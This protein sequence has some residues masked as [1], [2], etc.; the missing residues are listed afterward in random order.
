MRK[1]HVDRNAY[2][3]IGLGLFGTALALELVHAGKHVIVLDNDE[4]KLNG[5]KEDITSAHLVS[6]ITAEVLQDSGISDCGTVVIAIGR[7]IESNILA[8]LTVKE[9]G[10]PRVISKAMSD[11]HGRV[12]EKIGAEIILPERDSALRLS[13]SLLT[14]RTL[15]FLELENDISITEVPLPPAFAGKTIGEMDFRTSFHLNIIAITREE[16][17]FIEFDSS[18]TFQTGDELVVIGK[19]E[20]VSRFMKTKDS[21]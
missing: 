9:V 14:L 17:T 13:R 21:M 7:D 12:L 8:T 3:I 1:K 4:E 6:A 19:N 11:A 2:G 15:D 5:V 20:D 16:L 10:V 18:F